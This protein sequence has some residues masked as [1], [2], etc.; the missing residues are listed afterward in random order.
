M[1][2]ALVVHLGFWRVMPLAA[3]YGTSTGSDP[4]CAIDC[5]TLAA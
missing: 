4:G 1:P 3:S 5:F 2:E